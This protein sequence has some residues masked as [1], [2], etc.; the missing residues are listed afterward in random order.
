ALRARRRQLLL[1]LLVLVLGVEDVAEPADEVAYRLEGPAGAVLDRGED[2]LGAGLDAVEEA[3]AA[4]T[5][6]AGEEHDRQGHQN[7]EYGPSPADHLLVVQDEKPPRS[8]LIPATLARVSV[9]AVD[10]LEFLQRPTGTD[11]DAR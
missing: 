4:L 7:G 11:C 3:A 6:V 5:E 8:R 1:Q 9:R 2:R 10:R